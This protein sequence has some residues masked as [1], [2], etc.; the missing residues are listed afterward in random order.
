MCIRDR[1]HTIWDGVPDKFNANRVNAGWLAEARKVRANT[2]D[3]ADWPA[4]WASQ[5]MVQAD[6]AYQGLNFSPRKDKHWTVVLPAGYNARADAIKRQQLTLGGARL[7]QV[8]KATL[9]R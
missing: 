5:S 4:R 7:A 2:G 3:P 1:L 6:L 8:L 9:G